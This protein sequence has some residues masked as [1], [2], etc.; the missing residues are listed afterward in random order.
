MNERQ[1]T[2]T[3]RKVEEDPSSFILDAMAMGPSQAIE[4]I[5]SRG[6]DELV[7]QTKKL[8]TDGSAH[9]AWAKWG[10]VWGDPDASDP[11]FRAVT[12]PA[13]WKLKR[14]SHSMWSDLVDDKERKRAC[15]FYKAASYD[16][17]ASLT[18]LRRL[19]ASRNYI[20]PNVMPHNPEDHA[21]Y[22]IQGVVKD[23][24]GHTVW[25]GQVNPYSIV[26]NALDRMM[27][28]E[29]TLKQAERWLDEHYP[30]WRDFGAYWE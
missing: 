1:I 3:T 5:E 25:S 24:D 27:I 15:V 20:Y 23:S 4:N 16:R 21:A 8:P 14:A 11:I 7:S 6:Q 10:V 28:H 29:S 30:E 13:G 12:L 22:S 18:P 9:E 2:N 17:H 26:N 19:E